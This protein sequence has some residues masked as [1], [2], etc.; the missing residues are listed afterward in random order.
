MSDEIKVGDAVEI[1]KDLPKADGVVVAFRGDVGQVTLLLTPNE[2][3][4]FIAGVRVK[5]CEYDVA[6]RPGEVRKLVL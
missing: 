6:V 5:S 1:L 2:N 4:P 3:A